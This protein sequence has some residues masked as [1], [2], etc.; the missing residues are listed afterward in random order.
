MKPF[1]PHK[2][3]KALRTFRPTRRPAGVFSIAVAFCDA[4]LLALAFFLAVS[5]F[6]LQPGINISLPKSPFTGGAQFGSMVLSI[7][8]G[9]WFY[10]N[11]KRL[12]AP[13][14]ETAL[15]EAAEKNPGAPL[16]IEAD[17]AVQHGRVVEAWNA[18]Q[19]A[20]I[21]EVSIATDIA[22]LEETS[23]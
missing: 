14:L 21:S 17:E 6:V 2:Q 5:P 19:R 12:D 23:P 22:V 8:S 18:A 20:G 3:S 10:F 4:S 9:G 15:K 1:D 13:R 16:I 11:D 7:T